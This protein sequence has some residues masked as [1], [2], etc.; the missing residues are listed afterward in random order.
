MKE[1]DLFWS[2]KHLG[3]VL[4]NL[5][6]RDFHATSFSTYEFS[7]LYTTLPQFLIKDNLNDHIEI[8]FQRQDSRAEHFLYFN[9]ST[10]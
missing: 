2:I 5:K 3:K 7:T 10:I 4:V 6:A 8:T 1:L 9:S